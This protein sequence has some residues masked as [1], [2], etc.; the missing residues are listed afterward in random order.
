MEIRKIVEKDF[1]FKFFFLKYEISKTKLHV[2]LFKKNYSMTTLDRFN[3]LR[4]VLAEL[5][6]QYC[7]CV[8]QL[9]VLVSVDLVQLGL[10]KLF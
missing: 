3:G 9:I 1:N 2:S 7:I 5:T 10:E 8:V 4:N 6:D